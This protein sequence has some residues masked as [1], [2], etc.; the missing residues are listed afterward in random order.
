MSTTAVAIIKCFMKL[1]QKSNCRK[2]SQKI[3]AVKY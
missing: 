2:L 1:K 3:L